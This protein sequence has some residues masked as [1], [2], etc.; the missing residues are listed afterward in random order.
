MQIVF[1]TA[2][3]APYV[4]V[5]GLADAAAG[6]V[7]ALRESG[8]GVEVVLPDYGGLPF[9]AIQE[10]HLELPGWAGEAIA[11]SGVLAGGE[12]VTLVRAPSLARPHPYM[13]EFGVGWED[14]DYRFFVFSA[15]VAALTQ[16]RQPDLIHVNDWH[17]SA[18]L[19]FLET[20]LPSVL[21]IHNLAYQGHADGWW[22]EQIT[23]HSQAFEWWGGTNP[24]TGG[25]ALADRVVTVSP[26][27]A[28][29]V[30]RPETGFGVHEALA[31]KGADFVGILNGI[32]T[33]VWNPADDPHLSVTYDSRTASRKRRI[34][35]DL[36]GELG[37]AESEDPIIGMVTRLTDQKG[38]DIALDATEVL[39]EIGARMVVLGSGDRWLADAARN[40][41]SLIPDRFAFR[42]GYDEGL[43]HRIFGGSD[44]Y[45]MP[46][47]FEP[48]GLTQMQAMRYGSIPIVTDVGGLHDTVVDADIYPE[49][50]NGFVAEEVSAESVSDAMRRA[51]KAWRSTRRRG[52]IRKAG[53]TRDWSWTVPARDYAALYEAV[54]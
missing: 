34:G 14:N 31:A 45:L 49:S 32:E 39:P 35:R 23:H 40:V 47:R 9:E 8:I 52:A 33:D 28:A 10:V 53:M 17:T 22:L 29:E 18:A 20:P 43:S 26:T 16:L 15:A 30:L 27:F 4:K 41:Q 38:V 5:G 25:I 6:L 42:D 54:I 12:A 11:V 21:T 50:G 51:V 19:G 46:S 24:L 48:G 13:D 3:L 2:E 1:A 44:L 37:W 36:A 7:H